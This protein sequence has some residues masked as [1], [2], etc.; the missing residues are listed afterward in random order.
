MRLLL[1]TLVVSLFGL[2]VAAPSFAD[3]DVFESKRFETA[4]VSLLQA[5]EIAERESKGKAFK[6]ELDIEHGRVVWEIKLLTSLG[7]LEYEIDTESGRVSKIEDERVRGRLYSFIKGVS[8]KDI[9][10][11][12][13]SV[14]EAIALAERQTSAKAIELEIEREYE[15]VGRLEYEIT[16]RSAGSRHRVRVDAESGQVVSKH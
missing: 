5:I 2:A 9:D 15:R 12:K 3:S 16:L 11:A 13:S 10:G 14:A 7:L 6:A 8:L 1:T 4:K